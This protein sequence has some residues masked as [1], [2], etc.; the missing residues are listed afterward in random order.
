MNKFLTLTFFC[1]FS[2]FAFAQNQADTAKI[3]NLSY[4]SD[5]EKKCF[6]QLFFAKKCDTIGFLMS[7]SNSI[8][9][10]KV[11]AIKKDLDNFAIQLNTEGG[12]KKKNFKKYMDFVFA[13]THSKYFKKY[14]ENVSFDK[15]FVS[16]TYNCL[17]ASALYALLFER[18]G[19]K[20]FIKETPTHIYLVADPDN[21]AI[22]IESTSPTDGYFMPNEKFKKSY[23]GDLINNKMI[24]SDEVLNLGIDS[25]F[26]KHFYEND[27]INFQKLIGLHY[28][29]L[30]IKLIDLEQQDKAMETIEKAYLIYPAKRI[31]YLRKSLFVESLQKM[32]AYNKTI[33]DVQYMLR[34]LEFDTTSGIQAALTVDFEHL[35]NEHLIEKNDNAFFEAVYSLYKKQPFN[36]E[37]LEKITEIYLFY[38]G[39]AAQLKGENIKSFDFYVQLLK[40][41]SENVEYQNI[42]TTLFIMKEGLVG[43]DM[44]DKS[45]EDMLKT[46]K[47]LDSLLVEFPQFKKLPSIQAINYMFMILDFAEI[48][49]GGDEAK[50]LAALNEFE[51]QD[52]LPTEMLGKKA[53]FIGDVYI[54]IIRNLMKNG[55][56]GKID[57]W[58]ERYKTKYPNDKVYQERMQA[59]ITDIKKLHLDAP[60]SVRYDLIKKDIKKQKSKN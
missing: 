47:R 15:I 51:Q 18:L 28:N 21:N 29:N 38:H 34:S 6:E 1:C 37:H 20:Y 10:D 48:V 7:L 23:V 50:T 60:P 59:M 17:T 41:K 3:Q 35:A 54:E 42:V 31:N 36:P 57:E 33:E 22:L 25:I 46:R 14:E 58:V 13:Q 44:K 55:K 19:I 12:K 5:I 39:K 52:D 2:L 45:N 16:G 26:V 32:K 4:K 56:Y 30:A 49:D 27:N 53:K 43:E 9:A 8:T 24:T 11:E 40:L